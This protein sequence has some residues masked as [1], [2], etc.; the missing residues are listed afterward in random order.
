MKSLYP[1]ILPVLAVTIVCAVVAA[2]V[3]GGDAFVGALVGGGLVSIFLRANPAILEPAARAS[4][5]TGML[6]AMAVFTGKVMIMVVLLA[7]F[8]NVEAVADRVDPK[9]LGLTL[10][11]ASLASTAL[12]VRVFSRARVLAYDLG[13]NDDGTP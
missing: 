6:A 9:A 3:G 11:V 10:I 8:L 1:V 4:P 7:V 5:A 2:F 12:Q 13:N